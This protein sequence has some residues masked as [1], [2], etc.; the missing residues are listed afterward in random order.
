[1]AV[2]VSF[3]IPPSETTPARLQEI[4]F[5]LIPSEKLPSLWLQHGLHPLLPWFQTGR[6]GDT[7][8]THG[9]QAQRGGEDMRLVEQG[10]PSPAWSSHASCWSCWG[11]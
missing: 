10:S 7:E 3:S 1:M 6:Q 2:L 9:H 4:N 5:P 11:C 8:V